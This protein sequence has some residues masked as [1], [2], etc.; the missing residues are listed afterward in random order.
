MVYS[1]CKYILVIL[2]SDL[3][4]LEI[5][6]LIESLC[7]FASDVAHHGLYKRVEIKLCSIHPGECLQWWVYRGTLWPGV[8]ITLPPSNNTPKDEVPSVSKWFMA[9]LSLRGLSSWGI[10]YVVCAMIWAEV[11]VALEELRKKQKELSFE[12]VDTLVTSQLLQITK[13]IFTIIFYFRQAK[14]GRKFYL[15]IHVHNYFQQCF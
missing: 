7:N 9:V 5:S 6:N 10:R 12:A 11:Q 13:L 1:N 8:Y 15:C 14:D 2:N 3:K 4:F